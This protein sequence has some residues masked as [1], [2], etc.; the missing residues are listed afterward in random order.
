MS[1]NERYRNALSLMRIAQRMTEHGCLVDRE[2]IKGHNKRALARLNRYTTRFLEL[3]QLP[4]T[5]LGKQ[6]A[7]QT[8]AVRDHFFKTLRAPEVEFDKHTK[9]AQFNSAALSTYATAYKAEA[10]GPPAAALLGMR[11][12]RKI[13]EFCKAYALFSAKDG[14]IHFGFNALGTVTGRWTS[15]TK[16]R[17]VLPDGARKSYSVN[18]QQ[19]PSKVP[20]F[21]FEPGVSEPLV[22]SLRDIFIP[23]P[24]CVFLK[25]DYDQ[26]ELRLIAYVYGVKALLQVIESGG[27]AH[28]FT[29]AHLWPEFQLDPHAGK[30]AKNDTSPQAHLMRQCRDAAKSCAYAISYQM[31]STHGPGRYPQLTKTLKAIFPAINER[32]VAKL[33]ERFFSVYPEIKRGQL[34]VKDGVDARGY[35]ELSIDGRRLFYP[36][37]MRGYNQALNFPMQG[38]GGALCNRAL[39][40]LE[41]QLNWSAG[42]QVRFQVHDELVVQAPYSTAEKIARM[43]EAA[44]GKPAQIGASYVGIPAA[45]DPGLSWKATR[46]WEMFCIEYPNL[47]PR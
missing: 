42:E 23:D 25:A 34:S 6:G 41:P 7:G 33:A 28:M 29:A 1:A 39:L 15:S 38:T 9:R 16:L 21:E 18:A 46:P 13:M 36:A 12:N 27:D 35:A 3:T 5:A 22:E 37:S 8:Q 2:A 31:H 20:E 40:E 11:K 10:F 43:I 14:R 45:A 26:L 47:I 24:G 32:L 44:M 17:Q 19:I 4:I 30:P